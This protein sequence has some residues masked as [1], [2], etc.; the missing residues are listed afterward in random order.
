MIK[1]R[2][3]IEFL[4]RSYKKNKA[5]LKILKLGLINE[6]DNILSGIDY[7]REVVQTSN[8][9]SLDNAIIAR[10]NEIKR[11]EYDIGIVD[12][13]LESL[14]SRKDNQYK[15]VVNNYYIENKTYNEVMN[16]I[17]IY[18]RYHYFEICKKILNDFLELI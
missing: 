18:N 14:D 1:D 9:T 6:Q 2:K 17:N 3:Y 10:E 11:L 5:R 16:I 8:I 7:S 12:A 4:L 15:Q 13:L